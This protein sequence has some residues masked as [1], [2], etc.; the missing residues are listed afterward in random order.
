MSLLFTA[1]L[2][3]VQWLAM[4]LHSKKI[5]GLILGWGLSVLSLHGCVGS[6]RELWLPR[7]VQRR[8]SGVRRTDYFKLAIQT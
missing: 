8:A 1:L 4:L 6:L 7:T 5:L 3:A 2:T